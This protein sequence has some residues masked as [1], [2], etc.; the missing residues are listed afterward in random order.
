MADAYAEL[1]SELRALG[2]LEALDALL[3]WDQDVFMPP[4]GVN[5]RAELAA[6]VAA[7]K[8]ARR[9]SPRMAELLAQLPD[10]AEDT[11]QAT[12]IREARRP[13]RGPPTSRNAWS[14]RLPA[15][16]PWPER[17]GPP[18]A[19]PMIFPNSPPT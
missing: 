1:L 19:R 6:F 11:P 13:T 15:S 2:Q 18:P 14:R 4:R 17:P 10:S 12:N 5:P 8:H 9:T 7:E 3:E 16:P